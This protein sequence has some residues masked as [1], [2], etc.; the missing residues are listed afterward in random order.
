[1]TIKGPR[2]RGR[3]SARAKT[4]DA[5]LPKTVPYLQ[6]VSIVEDKA[7]HTWHARIVFKNRDGVHSTLVVPCSTLTKVG[8]LTDKLSDLG[9]QVPSDKEDRS[10]LT[11]YIASAQPY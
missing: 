6:V 11:R 4:T 3:A 9:Y 2:K 1:M 7:D 8:L 10:A 5:S